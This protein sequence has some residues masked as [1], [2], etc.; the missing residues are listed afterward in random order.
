[1]AVRLQVLLGLLQHLLRLGVPLLGPV[2]LLVRGDRLLVERLQLVL[3]LGHPAACLLELLGRLQGPRLH[4]GDPL[5][6]LAQL[7]LRLVGRRQRLVDERL[8]R[9]ALRLA[10]L[11]LLVGPLLQVGY[12]AQLGALGRRTRAGSCGE[13]DGRGDRHGVDHV[14]GADAGRGQRGDQQPAAHRGRGLLV[15]HRRVQGALHLVGDRIGELLTEV[16]GELPALLGDRRGQLAALP[17]QLAERVGVQ[18]GLRLPQRGAQLEDLGHLL[19]LVAHHHVDHPG[20]DRG[21]AQLGDPLREL[22]VPVGLGLLGPLVAGA[23]EVTRCEGVQLL[24]DAQQRVRGHGSRIVVATRRRGPAR[25]R[26]GPAGPGCAAGACAGCSARG[27]ARCGARGTA[28]RRSACRTVPWPP[29][30]AP[31]SRGR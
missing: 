27:S 26:S 4:L 23:R 15:D 6:G 20:R 8:G 29:G 7:L 21:L 25:W 13:A 22:G 17:G 19:A 5:A 11:R 3:E 28:A 14:R 10:R 1:M 12:D 18:V 16:T 24:G 9:G 2:L 30:A 31:P